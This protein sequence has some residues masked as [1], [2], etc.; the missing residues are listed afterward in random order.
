MLDQTIPRRIMH[1]GDHLPEPLGKN[2]GATAVET[3]LGA[4]GSSIA[5][6]YT[7]QGLQLLQKLM[8]L[9]T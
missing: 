3:L 7:A 4:L 9:K 2:T 5:G 6:T 8:I 1:Q